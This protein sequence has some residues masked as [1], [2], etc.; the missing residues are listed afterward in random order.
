M[1]RHAGAKAPMV[2]LSRG[3]GVAR[4]GSAFEVEKPP[5]PSRG[6]S[7]LVLRALEGFGGLQQATRSLEAFGDPFP[8]IS[9]KV[10]G[11]SF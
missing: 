4:P 10:W 1:R 6:L 2:S 8:V 9:T 11:I 7:G 3:L 5:P